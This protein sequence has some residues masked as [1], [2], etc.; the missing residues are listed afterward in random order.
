LFSA[1]AYKKVIFLNK[2]GS[3]FVS[4]SPTSGSEWAS[5]NS[6]AVAFAAAAFFA[7]FVLGGVDV[8]DVAAD[9]LLFLPPL[10]GL[11]SLA[12]SA[13][14][15]CAPPN[16][17]RPAFAFD[18]LAFPITVNNNKQQESMSRRAVDKKH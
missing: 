12:V 5:P 14:G 4:F 3:F 13:N 8:V 2:R 10:E 16:L 7:L 1:A 15:C 18:L 6:S 9:E 17:L 11:T